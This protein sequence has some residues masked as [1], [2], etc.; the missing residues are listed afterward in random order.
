MAVTTA[1]PADKSRKS[2]KQTVRSLYVG[3]SARSRRF[4]L[5]LLVF[6]VLTLIYFVAMTL[7]DDPQIFVPLE[8]AIAAVIALDLVARLWIAVNRQAFFTK[9]TTWL[10]IAIVFSLLLPLVF[11]SLV[12]LRVL[13]A[14]GL[15]RSFS[16]LRDLRGRYTWFREQE[17]LIQSSV[18]LFV[19]V[20]AF[21]AVVYVLQNRV[22]DSINSFIDALYFTVATLTTTGFGDITLVGDLGHL[23]AVIIMIVGIALFLRLLQTIFR[24]TKVRHCCETCG[25]K[26]HDT[27]ATHCKHCGDTIYIETSGTT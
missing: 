7:V 5:S 22:N 16:V 9:F 20:F 1:Q 24:P 11:E 26:R 13:R 25:L 3:A 12:F 6:D 21:S 4:R 10:D 18:N 27:D 2:L 15:L 23:L 8:L 17:D 14:L 19:F